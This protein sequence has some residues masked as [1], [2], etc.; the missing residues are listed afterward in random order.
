[1]S[2]KTQTNLVF[3]DVIECSGDDMEV[4]WQWVTT[5]PLAYKQKEPL[6]QITNPTFLT[7]V[8]EIKAGWYKGHLFLH[9]LTGESFFET[10]D[11]I[12]EECDII[13]LPNFTIAWKNK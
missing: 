4:D 11:A 2:K 12:E 13:K 9:L 8:G 3:H 10:Y 5:G 7:D 6:L 1:M